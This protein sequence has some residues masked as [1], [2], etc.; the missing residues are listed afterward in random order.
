MASPSWSTTQGNAVT[1]PSSP[2]AINLAA[3]PDEPTRPLPALEV[4]S[5][6]DPRLAGSGFDPRSLYAE[7]FWLGLLG[8]STLWMLRRFVRGLD[9]HPSGFRVNL[10]DTG[11]SLGL[12]ESVS[13]NS[14]TQ[15]T[16]AR[17]CQFGFALR[18]EPVR[19][20]VRTELPQLNRRQLARLPES[21]QAAHADWL[22]DRSREDD[23]RAT[24][25]ANGLAQD[26]ESFETI[27]R[28]LRSWGFA[29]SVAYDAARRAVARA[30][31]ITL[32]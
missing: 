19:L 29:G 9:A 5:W 4:V 21:L 16:I 26:G 6:P 13:R 28:Q 31:D 10:P 3:D 8:P 17:L 1:F 25:A 23:R 14:T 12:G 20:A 30:R 11:R 22:A 27:E 2:D 18:I 24:A 15:R 32:S 7:R